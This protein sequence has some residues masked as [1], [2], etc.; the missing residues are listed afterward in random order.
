MAQPLGASVPHPRNESNSCASLKRCEHSE[1][2][3]LKPTASSRTVGC[4][5]RYPA[6]PAFPTSSS[7]GRGKCKRRLRLYPPKPVVGSH[8]TSR[9]A[10]PAAPSTVGPMGSADT[11][12]FFFLEVSLSDL[13]LKLVEFSVLCQGPEVNQRSSLLPKARRAHAP[14]G[15]G[16]HAEPPAG[17]W[18]WTGARPGPRGA[19]A[20][21]S[22]LRRR[23]GRADASVLGKETVFCRVLEGHELG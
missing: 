2:A 22:R 21:T 1:R 13:Y 5:Y 7:P 3:E 11:R 15:R 8:D 9:A 6:D 16:R 12:L 10:P 17:A 18:G 19:E 4:F 20:R 14:G 23:T